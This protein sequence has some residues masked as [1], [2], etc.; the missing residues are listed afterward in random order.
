MLLLQS[1]QNNYMY[2]ILR[3]SI[4]NHLP[5]PT[6]TYGVGWGIAWL[7]CRAMTF[8]LSYGPTCFYRW[9]QSYTT[10]KNL[11][12]TESTDRPRYRA[13]LTAYATH[14]PLLPS[15][16][17][18]YIKCTKIKSYSHEVGS[19]AKTVSKPEERGSLFML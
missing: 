10:C 2:S 8:R 9:R 16:S 19:K 15:H 13:V 4:C 12:S 17:L 1:M 14:A 6:H 7:R 11:L 18:Y 5:P 3:T